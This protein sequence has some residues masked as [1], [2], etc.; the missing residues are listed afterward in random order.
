MV[1]R[2][3]DG[4]DFDEQV[5]GTSPLRRVLENPPSGEMALWGLAAAGGAVVSQTVSFHSSQF[6][7]PVPD[8]YTRVD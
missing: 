5:E 8:G 3:R 2:V 1:L 6:D 4:A 7:G